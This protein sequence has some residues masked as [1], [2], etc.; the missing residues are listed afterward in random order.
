MLKFG[1]T[2]FLKQW[3]GTNS[4]ENL[5]TALKTSLPSIIILVTMQQ[6]SSHCGTK[7]KIISGAKHKNLVNCFQSQ[8]S[9]VLATQHKHHA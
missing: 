4:F 9:W 3:H 1:A 5:K 8:F 2:W 6:G 7:I